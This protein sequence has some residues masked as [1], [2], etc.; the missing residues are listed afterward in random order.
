MHQRE[1]RRILDWN[2]KKAWSP[3][4]FDTGPWIELDFLDKRVIVKEYAMRAW[5]TNKYLVGGRSLFGRNSEDEPWETID[6]R[7][8][9]LLKDHGSGPVIFPSSTPEKTV[10]YLMFDGLLQGTGPK[11][12]SSFEFF[13]TLVILKDHMRDSVAPETFNTNSNRGKTRPSPLLPRETFCASREL[14]IELIV[15]FVL[16]IFD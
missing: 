11:F 2:A 15:V 8:E 10:R 1:P 12:I 13:G 6:E 9:M 14:I 3:D 7:Y 5:G 4:L 16:Q